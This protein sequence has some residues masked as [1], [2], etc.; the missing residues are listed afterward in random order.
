[1]FKTELKYERKRNQK[2]CNLEKE[3]SMISLCNAKS[4]KEKKKRLSHNLPFSFAKKSL[5]EL[6]FSLGR[7]FI[8]LIVFLFLKVWFLLEPHP[9]ESPDAGL[10][11]T[12]FLAI[13]MYY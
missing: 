4:E 10:I 13:R 12:D 1:M 8:S 6:F 9:L 7:Y 2:I 5:A 3:I 11:L